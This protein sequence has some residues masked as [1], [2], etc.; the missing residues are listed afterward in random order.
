MDRGVLL[1]HPLGHMQ[2]TVNLLR[3]SNWDGVSKHLHTPE[4]IVSEKAD[5][6]DI[7]NAELAS[8]CTGSGHGGR[9]HLHMQLNTGAELTEVKLTTTYRHGY[10]TTSIDA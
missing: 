3:D 6:A 8:T 5:A 7:A 10:D 2:H 9:N 4:E 1:R